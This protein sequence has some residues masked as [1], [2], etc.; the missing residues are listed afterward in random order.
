MSD[1]RDRA[2][3]QTSRSRTQRSQRT[4]SRAAQRGVSGKTTYATPN[5]SNK[6][7]EKIKTDRE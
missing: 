5:R 2:R 1:A 4:V 3:G 7:Q 6:I